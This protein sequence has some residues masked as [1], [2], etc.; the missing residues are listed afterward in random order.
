MHKNEL[1]LVWE[2]ELAILPAFL[3]VTQSNESDL[4]LSSTYKYVLKK[5]RSQEEGINIA[6]LAIAKRMLSDGMDMELV[7]K[8]TGLTEKQI[9]K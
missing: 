9:K 3:R 2:V 4:W 5:W 1:F 7:L 8:Y 6:N